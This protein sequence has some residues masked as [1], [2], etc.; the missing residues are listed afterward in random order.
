[1]TTVCIGSLKEFIVGN[2]GGDY[3]GVGLC[4]PHQFEFNSIYQ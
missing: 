4:P 1:M 2:R 3:D